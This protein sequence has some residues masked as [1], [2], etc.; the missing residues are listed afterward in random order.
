MDRPDNGET[1]YLPMTSGSEV[2]TRLP[3]SR[4]LIVAAFEHACINLRALTYMESNI[5]YAGHC[6]SS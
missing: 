5:D 4:L 2:F 3:R 6:F 1:D